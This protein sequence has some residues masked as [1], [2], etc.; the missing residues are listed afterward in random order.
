M[1]NFINPHSYILAA[2]R[3]V[4]FNVTLL[5][6]RQFATKDK[7]FYMFAFCFL[8]LCHIGS[9]PTKYFATVKIYVFDDPRIYNL[10]Q[11]AY[12]RSLCVRN[13]SLTKIYFLTDL[14]LFFIFFNMINRTFSVKRILRL[15]FLLPG[16]HTPPC[17]FC[18]FH[19]RFSDRY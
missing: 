19:H 6:Q 17:R 3:I 5:W 15:I 12:L 10:Y 4:E 16:L 13:F 8:T 1:S 9:I 18:L 7:F 11:L 14:Y 2:Y